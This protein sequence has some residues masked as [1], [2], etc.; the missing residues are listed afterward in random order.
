MKIT[1]EELETIQ[2]LEGYRDGSLIIEEDASYLG[3]D[4]SWSDSRLEVLVDEEKLEIE[5]IAY[6]FYDTERGSWVD[7]QERNEFFKEILLETLISWAITARGSRLPLR[8]S[9]F[10]VQ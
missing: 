9:I 2:K 5:V 6:Y 10:R 1:K 7:T 8:G 4:G 3:Q